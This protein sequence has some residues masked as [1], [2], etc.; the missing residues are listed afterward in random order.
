MKLSNIKDFFGLYKTIDQKTGSSKFN[1][2]TAKTKVVYIAGKGSDITGNN[3]ELITSTTDREVGITNFDSGNKLNKG[4][5][6]QV[7]GMRLL[8]DDTA[9]VA[10]RE[11]TWGKAP[12]APFLNGELEFHQNK[13]LSTNTV[14]SIAR[15]G[16]DIAVEDS[17]VGVIP[18]VLRSEVEFYIRL[19]SAGAIQAN[20]A[21]RLE[22]LTVEFTEEGVS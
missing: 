21:W 8:Y 14:T 17:F 5:N 19:K 7:V 1:G 11:A 9:D 10:P 20:H 13:L 6:L 12:T 18:F 16:A 3:G 4:R 2:E 15:A 22:L